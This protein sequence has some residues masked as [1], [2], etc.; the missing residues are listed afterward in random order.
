MTDAMSNAL[1]TVVDANAAVDDDQN[2]AELHFDGES[3]PEGQQR[4]QLLAD[5]AV[6]ALS[7]NNAPQAR[8]LIGQALHSVQDFYSHTNWVEL[9]NTGPHPSL[10][11]AGI[12]LNRLDANVATCSDCSF[13]VSSTCNNCNG[14]LATNQLTS[15]YYHGENRVKPNARKCSHGGGIDYYPPIASFPLTARYGIN[16]DSRSCDLS[17][18]YF[19]HERA[20]D[21][22]V[23]GS[24]QYIDMIRK[25][26]TDS[27][28]RNL[29]GVDQAASVYST[30]GTTSKVR[31]AL[32][33]ESSQN[34]KRD[35]GVTDET[36]MVELGKR[37][38]RITFMN[39]QSHS[40]HRRDQSE[41]SLA[42][43]F[44]AITSTSRGDY[45]FVYSDV[46]SSVSALDAGLIGTLALIRQV[47]IFAF[48]T[49]NNTSNSSA[50][51]PDL[52]DAIHASGGQVFLLADSEIDLTPTIISTLL[53][54]DGV[55]IARLAT[56]GSV[57]QNVTVPIDSTLH[58]VTFSVAGTSDATVYKPEGTS[59]SLK[60]DGLNV[61]TLGKG[62]FVTMTD[63]VPGN[64][65]V[66][67]P[68][69][70]EASSQISLT[71]S[72]SSTMDFDFS[73]NVLTG[74]PDHQGYS[75]IRGFP[76]ANINNLVSATIDTL[77][78]SLNGTIK[79][80]YRDV[81][82]SNAV[83]FNLTLIN[84]ANVTADGSLAN[85]TYYSNG[86][87]S[88]VLPHEDFYVYMTGPD[89]GNGH[90][91]Q[92]L[93]PHMFHASY[94]GISAPRG[95]TIHP[96]SHRNLTILVSNQAPTAVNI[97]LYLSD[98]AGWLVAQEGQESIGNGQLLVQLNGLA[99]NATREIPMSLS[100]PTN[101]D[102]GSTN[103]LSVI[104]SSFSLE[105]DDDDTEDEDSSA[106]VNF[107]FISQW[108]V[109]GTAMDDVFYYNGTV[110]GDSSGLDNY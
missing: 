39:H 106:D 81:N 107:T 97:S 6:Q 82:N 44:N 109:N 5:Q 33:V 68:A 77:P 60:D 86:T 40:L 79:V 96:G 78:S 7:T 56:S 91:F 101:A 28:L 104:A 45:L 21:L 57:A 47:R 85:L 76:T 16:K 1:K 58:N 103:A 23:G 51:D 75:P 61:V 54:D 84:E 35:D 59:I 11:V 110:G 102:L 30:S 55:D 83:P 32:G 71:V 88:N 24:K 67:F 53:R 95:S 41:D 20:A 105:G 49:T 50:L 25:R 34:F 2:R 72:G 70:V 29:F 98:G 87:N 27:Q 10:G 62:L 52:F 89:D 31:R 42:G 90:A 12:S 69:T 15:G 37:T 73:F 17:P 18:H 66:N 48:I 9:G 38:T 99:T 65:T 19:Y 26:L 13:D 3:F 92:R 64:W 8:S 14:N 63:P 94:I 80:Y 74:R 36:Y 46:Q 43:L 93:H 4:L 108:V 22:A 100:V